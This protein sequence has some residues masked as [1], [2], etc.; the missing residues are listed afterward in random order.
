MNPAAF[1][2]RMRQ[3]CFYIKFKQGDKV[4][5]GAENLLKQ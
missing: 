3:D 4:H 1:A 2:F 5:G